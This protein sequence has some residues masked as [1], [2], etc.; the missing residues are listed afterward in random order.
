M[1]KGCSDT[2]V[3]DLESAYVER[4][5]R[6]MHRTEARNASFIRALEEQPHPRRDELQLFA[7]EALEVGHLALHF[8][9]GGVGGGA[10]ALDAQL[11]FVG[12]VGAREGFVEGDELLGVEVEERLIEGLHAVL[13]GSGR[14]WAPDSTR[15]VGV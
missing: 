4:T 12:V 2:F 14:E 9:A 6:A 7:G 3:V 13:A 1:G 15:F 11:E 10:N 8:L 5:K